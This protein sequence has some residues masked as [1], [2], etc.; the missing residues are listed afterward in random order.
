MTHPNHDT[1]NAPAFALFN[2]PLSNYVHAGAAVMD[3]ISMIQAAP[4]EIREHVL[5]AWVTKE[6]NLPRSIRSLCA[7]TFLRVMTNTQF[8]DGLG[9]G[10]DDMLFNYGERTYQL[11]CQSDRHVLLTAPLIAVSFRTYQER[12]F[13]VA[14]SWATKTAD[15]RGF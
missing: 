10:F 2:A 11:H 13:A 14:H 4:L 7:S 6:M 3:P 5:E 9:I 1:V 8:N 15:G 12:N